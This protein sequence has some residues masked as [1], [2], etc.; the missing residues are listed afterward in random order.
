MTIVHTNHGQ[1]CFGVQS[2]E[3]GSTRKMSSHGW[4]HGVQLAKKWSWN[5]EHTRK[6]TPPPPDDR[7]ITHHHQKQ[8]PAGNGGERQPGPS[9]RIGKGATPPPPAAGP[10]QEGRETTP[11]DLSHDWRRTNH[12]TRPPP[13]A[14]AS[15]ERRGQE[16]E[17]PPRP[18][19][20]RAH[21]HQHMRRTQPHTDRNRHTG[22]TNAQNALKSDV[23]SLL[24]ESIYRPYAL[25][26]CIPLW[27]YDSMP[28]RKGV[29]GQMRADP[30]EIVA[31][32]REVVMPRT[33][34]VPP[35]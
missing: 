14:S 10:S 9:A 18:H 33:E 23:A 29:L 34:M 17:D 21:T 12:R 24:P 6:T 28:K 32:E 5:D 31:S 35:K 1:F 25:Q 3:P 30:C 7:K 11:G 19:T 27:T 13:A 22:A 4:R 2:P 20:T 15:R 8:T 16:P 26:L